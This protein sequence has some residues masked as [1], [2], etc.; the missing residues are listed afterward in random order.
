MAQWH[1]CANR[2]GEFEYAKS[3]R[4]RKS[5]DETSRRGKKTKRKKMK[6]GL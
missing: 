4:K 1:R 3:P 5:K 6:K 2:N